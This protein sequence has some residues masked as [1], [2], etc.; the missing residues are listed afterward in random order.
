MILLILEVVMPGTF[1]FLCLSAG[2]FLAALIAFLAGP[3]IKALWWTQWLGFIVGSTVAT[4]LSRRL[5][6]RLM[7]APGGAAGADALVGHVGVVVEDIVPLEKRGVVRVDGDEWRAVTPDDSNVPKGT[8]VK[9]V[10]VRGTRLIV[11]PVPQGEA[12]GAKGGE[13][14]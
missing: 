2:C 13:G 6:R 10:G 4:A 1:Y 14:G 12:E 3:H 5:A 7:E 9:V 11:E 8:K